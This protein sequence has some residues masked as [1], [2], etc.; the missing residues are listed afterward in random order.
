MCADETRSHL[1]K[2]TVPYTPPQS[3][4]TSP[5]D[6]ILALPTGLLQTISD[7]ETHH[8]H[9]QSP[10]TNASVQIPP[11]TRGFHKSF[12]NGVFGPIN[13]TLN[14][15]PPSHIPN[16][17]KWTEFFT[18]HLDTQPYIFPLPNP[19][20]TYGQIV[21]FTSQSTTETP[22]ATQGT[23][24]PTILRLSPDVD[25]YY[26]LGHFVVS[27]V[28]T[29]TSFD[30]VLKSLP[31]NDENT[32]HTKH[33][34]LKERDRALGSAATI[35]RNMPVD[36]YTLQ[37]VFFGE[38]QYKILVRAQE[39]FEALKSANNTINSLLE[40]HFNHF[41]GA[42]LTLAHQ[43]RLT[44]PTTMTRKLP[45]VP[46]FESHTD[47]NNHNTTGQ[48]VQPSNKVF[49]EPSSMRG[50]LPYRTEY[51]KMSKSKEY[52]TMSPSF[53]RANESLPHGPAPVSRV[54]SSDATNKSLSDTNCHHVNTPS[55]P[56][57]LSNK[58][59]DES[60]TTKRKLTFGDDPRWKKKRGLDSMDV[61]RIREF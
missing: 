46:V 38:E 39:R 52:S 48:S 47:I 17:V 31:E 14:N 53:P 21:H 33:K 32:K 55:I 24:F 1:S 15:V 6:A 41:E 2:E 60:P 59:R 35:T 61:N 10:V 51:E 28:I 9:H 37:Y 56:A 49:N 43:T 27:N 57:P 26:Y 8:S 30:Q 58:C 36:F 34:L 5:A 40:P 23:T 54:Q 29:T 44:E 45:S 4:P 22:R 7:L 19:L 16:S 20:Q 50:K 25:Q 18:I 11:T 13:C 3:E 12:L 42:S